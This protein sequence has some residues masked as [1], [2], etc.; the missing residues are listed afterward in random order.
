MDLKQDGDK[1]FRSKRYE[2]CIN[3]VD[4]IWRYETPYGG[5]AEQELRSEA[6]AKWKEYV[7]WRLQR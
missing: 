5:R 2:K 4:I 1:P 7:A 6:D 3:G